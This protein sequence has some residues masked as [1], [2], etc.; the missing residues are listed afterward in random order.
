MYFIDGI[1]EKKRSESW[2]D[3]CEGDI[4]VFLGIVRE[5]LWTSCLILCFR[6]L[7]D[8]WV[9]F[10]E[11]LIIAIQDRLN[12]LEFQVDGELIRAV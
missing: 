10:N 1:R 11:W 6:Q 4:N 5:M 3:V 9:S 12:V 2:D 7:I 8:E